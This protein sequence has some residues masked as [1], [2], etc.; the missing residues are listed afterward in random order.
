MVPVIHFGQPQ[1]DGIFQPPG[2]QPLQS[3]LAC[4]V[5]GQDGITSLNSDLQVPTFHN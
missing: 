3:N 5:G 4:L 1:R 2:L